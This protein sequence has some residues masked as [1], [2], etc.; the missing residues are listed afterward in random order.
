MPA[1]QPRETLDATGRR[2][3]WRRTGRTK[4]APVPRTPDARVPHR[5][6]HRNQGIAPQARCPVPVARL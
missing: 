6:R 3:A 4:G 1:P 2:S 5:R